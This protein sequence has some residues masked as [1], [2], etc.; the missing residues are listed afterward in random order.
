MVCGKQHMISGMG[1]SNLKLTCNQTSRVNFQAFAFGK[2][3][4]FFE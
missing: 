4:I 1:M 3:F 2:F